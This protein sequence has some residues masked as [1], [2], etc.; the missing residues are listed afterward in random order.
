M[1]S[2]A[3]SGTKFGTT[4]KDNGKSQEFSEYEN[5]AGTAVHTSLMASEEG[6]KA[7]AAVEESDENLLTFNGETKIEN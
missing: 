7:K 5:D 3:G 4:I 1:G 2:I 6:G